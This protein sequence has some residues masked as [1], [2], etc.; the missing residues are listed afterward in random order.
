[1]RSEMKGIMRF[2]ANN[3]AVETAEQGSILFLSGRIEE[4]QL[5]PPA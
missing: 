5:P 2:Q 3:P 4:F 1:M